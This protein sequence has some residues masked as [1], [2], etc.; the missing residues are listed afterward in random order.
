MK[1]SL[2]ASALALAM[3]AAPAIAHDTGTP[4]AHGHINKRPHAHAGAPRIVKQVRISCFRGPLA[5][6]AWDHPEAVFIE[7]LIAIGYDYV[8]AWAIGERV[9]KDSAGVG[10]PDR[11]SD[12]LLNA[13][14]QMPSDH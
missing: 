14:E 4:H 5:V 7:D 1:T 13:I 11:L 6:T 8:Q 2:I 12:A 3:F 10:D 9:C